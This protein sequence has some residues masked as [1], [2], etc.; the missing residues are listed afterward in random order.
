M[1][2]NYLK[3]TELHFVRDATIR[4]EKNTVWLIYDSVTADGYQSIKY[5]MKLLKKDYYPGKVT[6][7]NPEG[8]ILQSD[9]TPGIHVM[10]VSRFKSRNYVSKYYDHNNK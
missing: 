4:V 8:S 2:A 9:H 10:R 5:E 7:Y 6:F 3:K 1:P